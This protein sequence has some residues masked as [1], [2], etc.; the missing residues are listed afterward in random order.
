M[1]VEAL[2]SIINGCFKFWTLKMVK[3]DNLYN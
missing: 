2:F 1:L 3:M